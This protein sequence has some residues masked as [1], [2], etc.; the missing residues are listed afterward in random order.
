MYYIYLFKNFIYL[1]LAVLGPATF[2]LSLVTVSRGYSLIVVPRGIW[3]LV[4]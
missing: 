1:L 4:P 3:D 2:R